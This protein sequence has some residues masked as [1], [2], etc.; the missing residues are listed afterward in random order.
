LNLLL[1]TFFELRYLL[2]RTPW[3]TR[4]SPPELLEFLD[5]QAPARALDIGC[6]TGTNCLT[7]ASR[8]WQA[9]GLDFSFGAI[10]LARQRAR[11]AG[12][13]IDFRRGDVG[14][15]RD[16]PGPFDLALDIGCYHSLKPG[17]RQGYAHELGRLVRPQ[18]TVL[19]YGFLIPDDTAALHGIAEHELE[20]RFGGDFLQ[21]ALVRGTDRQRPSAWFTLKRIGR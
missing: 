10:R 2:G 12:L 16:L 15:L 21:T 9:T 7:L 11:Q 3:D 17:Q 18:G 1:W 5:T 8:G 13:P 4:L 20:R 14:A 19:M 6:G